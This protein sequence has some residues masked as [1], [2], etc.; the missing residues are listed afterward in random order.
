MSETISR[1]AAI[2]ELERAKVRVNHS[3]ERAIG[4]G[5]IEILD[6][7]EKNIK[8]LPP[9]QPDKYWKEQCQSYE[10][11]INKLRESL[12]TQPKIIRCKDCRYY[13]SEEKECLDLLGHGRR[14]EEDD[15]CSY[16]EKGEETE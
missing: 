15:Y 8:A 6:D 12:S 10:R 14:W 7:V 4:R 13:N 1:D 3:V 2:N 16:A 9:T 5:I 11:T